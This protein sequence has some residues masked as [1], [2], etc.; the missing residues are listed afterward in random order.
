MQNDYF[1]IMTKHLKG[2]R[3]LTLLGLSGAMF[4][5]SCVNTKNVTYF[6]NLSAEKR[7][8]M[9]SVAKFTEPIIQA[10]DILA[11]SINTID[12]QSSEVVNQAGTFVNSGT[13][14]TSNRQPLN[15][16]L[17]DKNGEV[18]LSL[19]GNIK[20][21]GL[22]TFQARELIRKEA[23][24]NLKSPN[25]TVRFANFKVSVLGEVNRPSAYTV[26]NEKVSV[27]D[28]LSLAG[29]LTI[30]GKRENVLVIRDNDGQKVFGRLN[31]NSTETF[32]NPFYY[33]KQN[34]VVY[35]EPNSARASTVNGNTRTTIALALS[36]ISTLV[37]VLT[38]VY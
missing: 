38:R 29:D 19:I 22:T 12:A 36:A 32:T 16:Y 13:N 2:K 28:A 3:L 25:V 8:V 11:I 34:D 31:L 7:S 6:Q 21:A 33:L 10:D 26:P 17:V 27:L 37:L 30:Y 20:V 5:T 15:G 35:V 23:S 4:I 24:K 1:S 18:E 9:E 14:S